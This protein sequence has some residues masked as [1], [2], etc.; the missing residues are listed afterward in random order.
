MATFEQTGTVTVTNGSRT[1]TGSGSAWLAGYDGTALNIAGA[2]Y[3]VA[4]IDSPNSLTLIEPYPGAT[5]SQLSYTL[6]PLKNENYDLSKK[7]QK[8]IDI[9][10]DL[11]DATVGPQGP[12]GEQ[13]PEGPAGKSGDSGF[14][15]I[16]N[17]T[18]FTPQP[19]GGAGVYM[20]VP[21]AEGDPGVALTQSAQVY[22]PI[23]KM[24]EAGIGMWIKS[25]T[26]GYAL[27]LGLTNAPAPQPDVPT[28][29]LDLAGTGD[30]FVSPGT[31]FPLNLSIGE[32]T[33]TF[34]ITKPSSIPIKKTVYTPGPVDRGADWTYI[35]AQKMW[36]PAGPGVAADAIMKV[37]GFTPTWNENRLVIKPSNY[38]VLTSAPIGAE[39]PITSDPQTSMVP[40]GIRF[41]IKCLIPEGADGILGMVGY[42]GV[43]DITLKYNWSN[44]VLIGLSSPTGGG[45]TYMGY[46]ALVKR[47]TV[48][49]YEVLW[50][51][52]I[53]G[54]G[55]FVSVFVDGQQLNNREKTEQKVALAAASRLYIGSSHGNPANGI[56]G[57]EFESAGVTFTTIE[58]AV[59]YYDIDNGPITRDELNSLVVDA[60]GLT[61][62]VAKQTLSYTSSANQKYDLGVTIGEMT[63]PQYR[64][65]KAVLEDWSSGT[66]I[67]H[68]K[69]LIMT[70]PAAQNVRFEDN[71]LYGAQPAW[72]EV[73]PQ[74][75]C[76]NINGINYYCEG[77]RMGTY[78]Q[79]QFFYDWDA[80]KMPK[81][82]FGNPRDNESYM[83][84]H[85]WLIYDKD[86]TLIAR[87]EQPNGQPLNSSSMKPVW[88]G[89]YDGVGNAITTTENP[90][91]NFGTVRSSVIWRSHDCEPYTKA[92]VWK[93]VPVFEQRV[94][95][96]CYSGFSTNGGDLRIFGDKGQNNGFGN[97]LTMS[98]E[99]TTYEGIKAQA[100]E[101]AERLPWKHLYRSR[102][103]AA[104][105]AV[106]LKYTPFN[107]QARSPLTG[108]GG[109]R[110]DR[111]SMPEMAARYVLNMGKSD[112]VHPMTQTPMEKIVLDY[113]TGYASDPYHALEEGRPTP[114]FKGNARRRV[115]LRNHYYGPGEMSVGESQAWYMQSGR[116]SEWVKNLFPLRVSPGSGSA[117]DPAR[118]M[119]GTNSIDDLHAHQFPHWGS[120]LF[121]SPEFAFLG[122]RFMDQVRLYSNTIIGDQY[123]L[124]SIGNRAAAWK[125]QHAVMAWKTASRGSS[126]LYNRDEVLDWV[127]FDFESF[128]DQYYNANPGVLNP[129]SS[130][131]DGE[132]KIDQVRCLLASSARFG[133]TSLTDN[134]AVHTH[135]FM[136]GYWLAALH[137]GERLGFNEA[138]RNASPKA[139]AVIDWLISAHRKRIVGRIRNPLINSIYTFQTPIWSWAQINASGGDVSKLP[140]TFEEV[141]MAQQYRCRTWDEVYWPGAN[142]PE[143]APRDGQANDQ[144]LAGPALLKDMGLTGSDLDACVEIAEQRFQQK[145]AEQTALGPDNAG[146]SWFLYHQATN[147]RPIKPTS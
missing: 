17:F 131:L 35:A 73:V 43:G 88:E 25:T 68:P 126:R 46:S 121:K 84:P 44:E 23:A 102:G 56:N 86:N 27:T 138:L 113:F 108:P 116:V 66:P 94:P 49:T 76:P 145:L 55:G 36:R 127:V 124:F 78:V 119:F 58:N 99:P 71:G 137:I 10:G 142:G 34:T 18:Q 8:I 97:W 64:A 147:N 5:A 140:Q 62:P 139:K 117:G 144:M 136:V 57:M 120:M 20:I 2:V 98:Y 132:G 141:D 92:D 22:L 7:V 63:V 93:R 125:F 90:H 104:C 26:S 100:S 123:G 16:V 69:Q 107:Q 11:V 59:R 115:V 128:H 33:Q 29:N 106:F 41:K 83:V 111:Q 39:F 79:F 118:P 54:K 103:P 60:S 9:A 15:S 67:A 77:I 74:G 37:E 6:L 129:P 80:S 87:V 51:N 47:G 40:A 52:N 3:P 75:E 143:W 4:S 38:E 1:V 14:G 114:V 82:P 65:Y 105:G 45:D 122:H 109:V 81:N 21:V 28:E 24:K 32:T 112:N 134:D 70:K 96:A 31:I 95:F 133:I 53:G 13:G 110:D 101:A 42:Y 61:D 50:E 85:K 146:S 130:L 135:D 72:T 12:K 91:F 19:A 48:Q 30:V 89:Q